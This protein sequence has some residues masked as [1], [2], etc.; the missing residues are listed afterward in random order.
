MLLKML[1]S[2]YH[3]TYHLTSIYVHLYANI[4][5]HI[6]QTSPL[7]AKMCHHE[8]LSAILYLCY[9]DIFAS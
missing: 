4:Q 9:L 2:P 5:L 7:G 8:D 6:T 1:F 3:Q